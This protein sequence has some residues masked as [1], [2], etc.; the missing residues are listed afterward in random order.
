MRSIMTLSTILATIMALVLTTSSYSA[1]VLKDG[2]LLIEHNSTDE[3]TGFQG[4]GDGD[5]WNQLTISGP[6]GEPVVTETIASGDMYLRG[7]DFTDATVRSRYRCA[8][9]EAHIFDH[10]EIARRCEV[11][12]TLKIVPEIV[13]T[14]RVRAVL[15]AVD[16]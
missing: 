13:R 1:P 14:E 11:A 9:D 10:A 7:E 3:D 15:M 8:E 4:F 6:G 5:P 16:E 12:H 2:K